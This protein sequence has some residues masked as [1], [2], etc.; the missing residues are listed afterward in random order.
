MEPA[1]A[2]S[3]NRWQMGRAQERLKQAKTVAVRCDQLPRRAH[4]KEGVD[5][6]ERF[7]A[8]AL[9]QQFDRFGY[10]PDDVLARC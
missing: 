3:G 7:R 2:T 6:V 1:V 10:A 5:L 8:I 4:G 9:D